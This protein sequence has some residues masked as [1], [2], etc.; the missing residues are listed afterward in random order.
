[1]NLKTGIPLSKKSTAE[2]KPKWCRSKAG[3]MVLNTYTADP[4][5]YDADAELARLLAVHE[6]KL[7]EAATDPTQVT[8]G[9]GPDVLM[10]W[11]TE[12][13]DDPV[14]GHGN[15]PHAGPVMAEGS[16]WMKIN[17]TPVCREGHLASCGHP[18]TGRPWWR[19]PQ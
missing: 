6:A 15:G 12:F 8:L 13:F 16:P 7:A 4:A 17:G 2:A 10:G 14:T 18:S 11:D 9:D 5:D 19:I 3:D 1:M